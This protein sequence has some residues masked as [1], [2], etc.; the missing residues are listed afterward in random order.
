MFSKVEA[1]LLSEINHDTFRA[2]HVFLSPISFLYRIAVAF[3]NFLFDKKILRTY[4]SSKKV[5]SIG[6]LTAGGTGKTHLTYLIAKSVGKKVGILERGYKAKIRR[7]DSFLVQNKDEGDEAFM[8]KEKLNFAKVIVGKNRVRSSKLAE[9]LDVD[10]ILM[11]DGMQ[12]RYLYRDI[13]V[14]M[15]HLEDVFKPNYFLP[16]GLYRDNLKRLRNVD[17]IFVNAITKE[18]DFLK[19]VSYFSKWT[20][21]KIIGGAYQ[22]SNFPALSKPRCAAFAGIGKP[23]TFFSMIKESGGKLVLK[24]TLLDHQKLENPELFKIEAK[25]AS[26]DYIFCTEKDYVKLTPIEREGIYP[27]KVDLNITFG[28]ENFDSLIREILCSV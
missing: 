16:R 3:R 5:V 21:A 12:H 26:I 23:E 10:Y 22:F 17:F 18:E 7:K 6:N 1:F 14:C 2:S 28:K 24:N 19:A 20:K 25:N 15:F 13:E 9:A 11:D 8:L 4:K 27:L